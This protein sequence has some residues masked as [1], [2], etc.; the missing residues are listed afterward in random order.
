MGTLQDTANQL[1]I[2]RQMRRVPSTGKMV[3]DFYYKGQKLEG[4]NALGTAVQIAQALQ[5]VEAYNAAKDAYTANPNVITG[6]DLQAKSAQV[7]LA[8][9]NPTQFSN[10]GRSATDIARAKAISNAVGQQ[11]ITNANA[12]LKAMTDLGYDY[13][14][15]EGDPLFWGTAGIVAAGLIGPAALGMM[16]SSGA[17]SGAAGA[18]GSSSLSPAFDGY[19]LGGSS[20]ISAGAGYG[21]IGA[22]SIPST[23]SILSGASSALGGGDMNVL[24]GITGGSSGSGLTG[25]LLTTGSNLIGNLVGGQQQQAAAGAAS[26][27]Q[28]Q[29]SNAAIAEQRRQFDAMQKLLQ[30]YVEAGT[31]AVSQQSALAGAQGPEAQRAAID[32]ISQSPEM[33]ALVQ[34]GENAILQNASA[35]GGLRGGNV[36]GTLAQ[37]RPQ[38]LSNLINQQ[39]SRLGGLTGIGQASAAGVGA[40]GQALG[41]NIAQQ[42]GNIGSAQAGGILGAAQGRSQMVNA[43]LQAL[44]TLYGQTGGIF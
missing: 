39:Y 37:F 38:M 40:A 7:N 6:T 27:A 1:G 32:A 4:A 3:S 20:G 26:G 9:T 33:Q 14:G 43:P 31:G 44:G 25:A 8:G 29:A 35:T 17:S 28:I 19:S 24:S 5:N 13:T 12:D 16:G 36:Q 41:S 21:G 2:T 23:S 42:Y 15:G 10:T 34:Q 30:P 22:S 18:A 11:N